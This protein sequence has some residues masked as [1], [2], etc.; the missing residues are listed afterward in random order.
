MRRPVD[1]ANLGSDELGGVYESL[2][3]LHPK[4]DTD[5]GPFTLETAPGHERKTTSSYYTRTPLINC[6]PERDSNLQQTS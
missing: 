5:E 1:F 6:L 2:L 4:I 3:E